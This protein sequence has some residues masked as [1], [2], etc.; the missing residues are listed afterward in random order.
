[1]TIGSTLSITSMSFEKR[2][3]IR[4]SGVVSKKL[5]GAFKDLEKS[6]LCITLAANTVPSESKSDPI[7]IASATL[8]I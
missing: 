3:I 2:L 8:I 4:P 7:N 1:M 6:A 5:I